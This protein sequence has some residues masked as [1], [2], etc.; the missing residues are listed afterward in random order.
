[1]ND[2]SLSEVLQLCVLIVDI[3]RLCYTI[4]SAKK[5]P[6]VTTNN[7]RLAEK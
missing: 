2:I 1:M 3:I 7:E 6:P 5:E 4:F